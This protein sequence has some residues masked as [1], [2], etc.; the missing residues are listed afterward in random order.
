[1]RPIAGRE[2]HAN[3]MKDFFRYLG[4]IARHG[5]AIG[6]TSL[7]ILGE[8]VRLSGREI[9]VPRWVDIALLLVGIVWGGYVVYRDKPLPELSGPTGPTPSSAFYSQLST[10]PRH[11]PTAEIVIGYA[12]KEDLRFSEKEFDAID[13]WMESLRPD[14]VPSR[15]DL[16]FIRRQVESGHELL[17]HCQANPPGP[18]FSID[19]VIDTHP[20]DD[21]T[22]VDLQELFAF[23]RFVVEKLQT[24]SAALNA[25]PIR[26]AVALQPYPSERGPIVDLSLVGL[27]YATSTGV[28]GN[29]IPWQEIIDPCDRKVLRQFPILAARSLLRHFGYRGVDE[30]LLALEEQ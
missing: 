22:A 19:K 11:L 16:S 5:F 14:T 20:I 10:L 18:V 7:G 6:L 12:V 25:Q 3:K 24:L 13:A 27:P 8:V 30:T 17:W 28:A 15:T 23:W 29:V 4:Q 26:I 1:M 21:G 9:P 2:N